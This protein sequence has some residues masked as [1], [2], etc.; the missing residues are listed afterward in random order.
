MTAAGEIMDHATRALIARMTAGLSPAALWATWADWAIHL[1]TSP[2]KQSQLASK[3]LRK[4]IRLQ[5]Y[6]AS[7]AFSHAADEPCI[8]PLAQDRR[9]RHESWQKPPFNLI[10]QSFLLTQQWWHN[11]TTGVRGVTPGH[12]RAAEFAARQV[13]DIF[14]PSNFIA[15]N[16]ELLER[17]R[18]ELGQNLVRGAQNLVEDLDRMAAGKPPVG[19]EDFRVGLDVAVTPG[20]V[21]YRNR[22]IELIQYAPAT[23]KVR[24]EP[25]LIVPAWIMKYYILDLSPANSMVRYLTERGFTVFMISWRNPSPE[26]RDL[27]MEDYRKLG[28]MA[29]LDAIGGICPGQKV[30]AVGYCLGG[31]LLSIAAAAMARDG[32]DRLQSISY[33]AAQSDFSEAGELMLFI[34]ESEVTFLEDMMWEQGFLDAKQMAGAFQ[35]LHSNDLIWSRMLRVYLMGERDPMNDLM[36]WNADTTRMPFRMHSE[37]LRKLFLDNELSAGKYEVE[38]RPVALGDIRVPVFAVGTETDHVAPWRSV[39][40]VH[41]QTDGEVTFVLTKGGHNA[42]VVSEPGH[43]RRHYRIDMRTHDMN[44]R[45][46][47]EWLQKATLREGS[48]WP[49]WCDWLEARSGEPATPPGLGFAAEPGLPDAP[50][51]YVL[52]T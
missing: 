36:A 20:K 33:F 1:A 31:T 7:C 11:A 46:P 28:P 52:M 18:D 43:P 30:H 39:F 40:K 4:A 44:H 27:G 37:Y 3:A 10:Y 5:R 14:S 24:P 34:S 48:W 42:G 49:A 6:A 8:E 38:G 45:S 41:Q 23:D 19:A 15:T 17:T 32:D 21:V 29:A 26:D 50:G 12:E 13:L 35:L 16:P 47:D 9:F 51:T 2:G 22:L 25:I